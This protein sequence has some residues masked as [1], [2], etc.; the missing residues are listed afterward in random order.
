MIQETKTFSFVK[1]FL[2]IF[3]GWGLTACD[4]KASDSS[5]LSLVLPISSSQQKQVS[6]LSGELAHLVVNI[7]GPGLPG[8][9]ILQVWDQCKDCAVS[10]PVPNPFIID[11]IPYS[12]DPRLIQVL[13][14]YQDSDYGMAFFYGD[15]LA[16]MNQPD[17][18]TVI[19]LDLLNSSSAMTSGRIAGRY[20]DWS[21]GGPT[22]RVNI[23]Y[24]PPGKPRMVIQKSSIIN[25]WFEF[26]AL[27][28]INF[29]YVLED[30]R[31][32]F[33]NVN[34]NSS[35][36]FANSRL[37]N[38]NIPEHESSRDSVWSTEEASKLVLGWFGDTTW[39]ASKSWCYDTGSNYQYSN[40]AVLGSSGATK[41]I[42]S[43][44][45][46]GSQY[47]SYQG[48]LDISDSLCQNSA[49][50]FDST[51]LSTASYIDNSH[52][53]GAIPFELPF[54]KIGSNGDT[55]VVSNAGDTTTI[56]YHF[57]PGLAVA[58]ANSMGKGFDGIS[59]FKAITQN[60]RLGKDDD[61]VLCERIAMGG[62][63]EFQRIAS[64][65]VT[66]SSG[67]LDVQ[68]PAT[69]R[70]MGVS[71]AVCPSRQGQF[72]NV[73]K[74]LSKSYFS[75]GG[76]QAGNGGGG[77]LV[78]FKIAGP[79]I[80]SNSVSPIYSTGLCVPFEIMLTDSSGN[81]VAA[82]NPLTLDVQLSGVTGAIYSDSVCSSNIGTNSAS[83]P[84]SSGS[85]SAKVY[86][87]NSSGGP[88]SIQFNIS[89][90]SKNYNQS[91]TL[92]SHSTPT[93]FQIPLSD[94]RASSGTCKEVVF[95]TGVPSASFHYD[96]VNTLTYVNLILQ[97]SGH[98][99]MATNS[100]N[101]FFSSDCSSSTPISDVTIP[102]NSFYGKF[103]FH[104]G[105]A[106]LQDQYIQ[107]SSS[108]FSTTDLLT[109]PVSYTHHLTFAFQAGSYFLGHCY[110]LT[111]ESKDINNTNQIVATSLS[112]FFNRS[113]NVDLFTDSSCGTIL[114]SNQGTIAAA[115]SQSS[116][117]GVKFNQI[118]PQFISVYSSRATTSQPGL[119]INSGSIL[120]SPYNLNS[121]RS[122]LPM[123]KMVYNVGDFLGWNPLATINNTGQV[124]TSNST[125]PQ[126]N[127]GNM[128]LNGSYYQGVT[129]TL[130]MAS[131]FTTVMLVKFI[132]PG[133]GLT[134]GSVLASENDRILINQTSSDF[135][136]SWLG[137]SETMPNVGEPW[138]VLFITRTYV[139]A[140]N[141]YGQIEINIPSV[142]GGTFL[143]S[144]GNQFVASTAQNTLTIGTPDS[145]N[146]SFS[147]EVK[148][149]LFMDNVLGNQV[150]IYNYFK[151]KYP[152]LGLP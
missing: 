18:S 52:R 80:L 81:I 13:A 17:V 139:D 11:G 149:V 1:I 132:N 84:I 25:G 145:L 59:V 78:D 63:P 74:I 99:N 43:A 67:Q 109:N 42:A 117:Y 60:E 39:T 58:D 50:R 56:Q 100:T 115:Q 15:I 102:A 135:T 82:N 9:T 30:G 19:N 24:E 92:T 68:I 3:L 124:F 144:P 53:D 143:V 116:T 21:G 16:V 36:F 4:R 107:L 66:T 152:T 93:H 33:D 121:V 140:T 2:T 142:G 89:S 138:R 123:S 151:A 90:L 98:A 85:T 122:W 108:G 141:L 57:L 77:T 7:S 103:A 130:S 34:L 128:S 150:D 136:M 48:G 76:M 125:H 119:N 94:L 38:I 29:D 49:V 91:F 72:F 40:L 88:G 120:W 62:F 45:A 32:L 134:N 37:L 148:E 71:L 137:D 35:E 10:M 12:A 112:F 110:P 111:V 113:A 26:F 54:R 28:I 147:G 61:E 75:G 96:Y 20:M 105:T 65:P 23:M 47:I 104:G 31:V 86:I 6:A 8:G 22:G 106:N 114:G 46:S 133:A 95:Y 41:L 118:A 129:A 83:I 126:Y 27:D 101:G 73:G 97:D 70:S 79:G 51:L 146:Y 87:Q 5:K 131:T 14:V 55:F 69:E 127:N 64:F 44:S